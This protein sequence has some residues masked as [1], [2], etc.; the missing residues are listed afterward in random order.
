HQ[1]DA[2]LPFDQA[3]P[4]EVIE[5]KVR[6][7]ILQSAALEQRWHQPITMESLRE[8]TARIAGATRM[9]DRLT[10]LY[11]ALGNDPLI[12]EECLARPALVG[13]LAR[14]RFASDPELQAG[15]RQEATELHAR[16]LD[17]GLRPD[18]DDPRR[19]VIDSSALDAPR[20]T[21]Q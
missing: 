4:A 15:A 12:I 13:R 17:G 16:L 19:T 5:R 7:Y 18:D 11:A 21:R 9:P 10:E 14:A 8:E 20:Q 6:D 1:K 2:T 3:V